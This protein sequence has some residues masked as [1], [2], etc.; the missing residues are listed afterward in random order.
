MTAPMTAS[1]RDLCTLA[2]IVSED[3]PDLPEEGLPE[4]LLNDLMGQIR[5]DEVCFVGMD[6]GQRTYWIGQEVPFTDTPGWEDLDRLHWEQYW[7]CQPCSYP[8]RTR[9]PAQCHQDHGLLLGP[10]MAL[11]RHVQ[12][13]LPAAGA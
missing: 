7:D 4:S 1:E 9:R 13:L 11:H 8:D 12:R 3:R 2:G 6:S 5:C 10:A